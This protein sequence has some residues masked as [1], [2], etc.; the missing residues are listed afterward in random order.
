[1]YFWSAFANL[2]MACAIKN[3]TD[4]V[5]RIDVHGP[6]V[7]FGIWGFHWTTSIGPGQQW[8]SP[9]HDRRFH[10][11]VGS[12][13]FVHDQNEHRKAEVVVQRSQGGHRLVR[14]TQA[15]V[16]A[17]ARERQ[18]ADERRRMEEAM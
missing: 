8:V 4:A 3:E 17:K 5:V 14:L 18:R 12:E 15:E 6:T 9:H 13:E 16:E 7:W 1:M 10:I 11:F 2:N